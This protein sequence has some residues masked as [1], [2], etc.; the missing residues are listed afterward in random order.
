MPVLIWGAVVMIMAFIVNRTRFG[1]YVYAIGGNPE[2]ALL[3][4]IPV[5]RVTVEALSAAVGAGDG[6]GDRGRSRV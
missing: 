6:G 5:K 3:V 4:G 2:A 1:R